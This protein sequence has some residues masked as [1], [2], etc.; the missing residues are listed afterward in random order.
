MQK[1]LYLLIA[2]TLSCSLYSQ[3]FTDFLTGTSYL[4]TG[5]EKF[6]LSDY[7]GAIA[8]Y[9]KAIELDPGYT[10]AYNYRGNA[11]DKLSD[12]SGAIA[13]Y[14]KAIELDPNYAK[15]YINRGLVKIQSGQKENG[16]LDLSKARE[17]G[18]EKA[19]DL[20]RKYCQ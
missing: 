13:D 11:K 9:T 18:F 5:Y 15:A 12:Y 10:E 7:K 2:L 4:N 1:L 16:C 19:N 20:I 8:D 6:K 3:T 17:L 14:T